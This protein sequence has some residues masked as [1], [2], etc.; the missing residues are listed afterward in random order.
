MI[1][2]SEVLADNNLLISYYNES[3]KIDFIRK[4]LVDHELFNWV[5]SSTPTATR[6][7][8]GKFVKRAQSPGR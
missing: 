6:N 2:G 3:G 4:R 8:D 1:I 5:E 7:W